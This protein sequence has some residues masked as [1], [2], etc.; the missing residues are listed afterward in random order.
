MLLQKRID[1]KVPPIIIRLHMYMYCNSKVRVRWAS[2]CS[3]YFNVT[4]G[5]KQGSV[6][7][8]VLFSMYVEDLI[9]TLETDGRGC[10]VGNQYYG[11]II[12][13]D[14]MFLLSP[15]LTGL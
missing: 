1:R 3:P 9:T 11:I 4:N 2:E 15:S 14:D 5:V 6:L 10:W 13:A 12:Y 8:P 7:S